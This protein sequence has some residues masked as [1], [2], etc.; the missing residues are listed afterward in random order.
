MNTERW[1]QIDELF[2]AVLECPAAERLTYLKKACG[3]DEKLRQEVESLL[4][5]SE[6]A[7]TFIELPAYEVAPELLTNSTAGIRVGESI[8]HYRIESLIGTGGMAEVYLARDERLGRKVA[9]K[10]L[11]PG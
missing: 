4:S 5:S 2:H 1:R 11:P 7:T 8:G 9:L 3:G 6:R 10:F